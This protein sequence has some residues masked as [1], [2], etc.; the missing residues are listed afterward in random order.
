MK[1]HLS[2][3]TIVFVVSLQTKKLHAI[4]TFCP[5]FVILSH[6]VLLITSYLLT[7]PYLDYVPTVTTAVNQELFLVLMLLWADGFA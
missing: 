7:C 4:L 2:N 1:Y 3:G 5:L 6:C